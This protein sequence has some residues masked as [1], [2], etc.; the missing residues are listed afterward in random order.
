MFQFQSGAIQRWTSVPP[1]SFSSMFQ[2]QSG[3]IQSDL[4]AKMNLSKIWFQFQSG[5]I[6]SPIAAGIVWNVPVSIPKWCDSKTIPLFFIARVN[7]RFN[8]KVVRFKAVNGIIDTESFYSFNSKVVRFKEGGNCY[9]G[10]GCV[11]FNSKV[12]RFKVWRNWWLWM[13]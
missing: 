11:C 8:S 4:R 13:L 3:A 6:Q 10:P 1:A 9:M 5:A 7:C 12:V 2:F